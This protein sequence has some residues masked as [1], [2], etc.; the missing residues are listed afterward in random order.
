VPEHVGRHQP[1]AKHPRGRPVAEVTQN[2][3][4]QRLDQAAPFAQQAL[5]LMHRIEGEPDLRIAEITQSAVHQ[6]RRAAGGAR[7]KIVS[8]DQQRLQAGAACFAQDARARDAA[9]DHD[10]IPRLVEIAPDSFAPVSVPHGSPQGTSR[11][12]GNPVYLFPCLLNQLAGIQQPIGI[13]SMTHR[14]D[15]L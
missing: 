14:L 13:E 6:L 1:H 2:E 8:F 3:E 15:Q 9:A 4:A 11:Q 5:A 12:G 7:C 10:Q